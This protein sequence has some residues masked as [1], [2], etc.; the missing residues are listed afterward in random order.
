MLLKKY[1]EILV[2]SSVVALTACGGGGSDSGGGAD[3]EVSDFVTTRLIQFHIR[4]DT[5]QPNQAQIACAR[6]IPSDDPDI[7]SKIQ[8][9]VDDNA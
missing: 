5:F 9:C 1:S 7:S 2:L 4:D 6:T 8:R 3:P